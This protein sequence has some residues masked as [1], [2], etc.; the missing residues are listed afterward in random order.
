MINTNKVQKQIDLGTDNP[1]RPEFEGTDGGN[2][3]TD[4]ISP[5][6]GASDDKSV[7]PAVLP[8][9]PPLSGKLLAYQQFLDSKN[10]K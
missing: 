3:A 7:K 8:S 10:N 6:E 4:V 2:V 9:Y 1:K 5:R